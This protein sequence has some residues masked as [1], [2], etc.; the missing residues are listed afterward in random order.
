MHISKIILVLLTVGVLALVPTIATAQPTTYEFDKTSGD[1]DTPGNWNPTSGPPQAGDTAI[2]GSGKT[3]TISE[4]DQ[5]ALHVE[6]VGTLIIKART[7]SM[8]A[9][10]GAAATLKLN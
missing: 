5:A 6:V 8:F 7:L 10:G 3:C 4:A 2:I 9:S 1:W